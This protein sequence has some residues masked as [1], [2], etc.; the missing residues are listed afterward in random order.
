MQMDDTAWLCEVLVRYSL[1]LRRSNDFAQALERCQQALNL[2]TNPQQ[3]YMK[4]HIGGGIIC[5][6]NAF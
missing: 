6:A 1:V 5:A 2:T 3:A 4:P